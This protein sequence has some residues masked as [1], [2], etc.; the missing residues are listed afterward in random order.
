MSSRTSFSRTPEPLAI[1]LMRSALILA[2]FVLFPRRHGIH[3]GSVAVKVALHRFFLALGHGAHAAEH[4]AGKEG[5]QLVNG[6]DFGHHFHLLVHVVEGEAPAHQALRQAHGLFLVHVFGRQIDEALNV[7][8]AEQTRDK[9]VGFELLQVLNAL[10]N[11]DV[12]DGCAG[13]GNG[14]RTTTTGRTIE[15]RDDD[16]RDRPASGRKRPP[17]RRPD[18][19]VRQ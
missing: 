18:R 15:F 1:R 17:D 10:A 8:H 3:D 16:A 19:L 6:A 4:A 5:H 11:T 13:G 9:P 12:D 7:A 2:S 14:Q